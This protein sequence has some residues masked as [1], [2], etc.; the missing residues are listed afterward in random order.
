MKPVRL[1]CFVLP[2]V[3]GCSVGRVDLGDPGRDDVPHGNGGDGNGGNGGDGTTG[4]PETGDPGQSSPSN[5]PETVLEGA[6]L[7]QIGE[8]R[9]FNVA[10]GKLYYSASSDGRV[11]L[12]R[13]DIASKANVLIDKDHGGSPYAADANGLFYFGLTP[14]PVEKA[15]IGIP[16]TSTTHL[17]EWF[18]RVSTYATAVA[19]DPKMVYWAE[20]GELDTFFRIARRGTFASPPTETAAFGP[21]V[22]N[23][24]EWFNHLV[25]DQGIGYAA[26]DRGRLVKFDLEIATTLLAE[27]GPTDGFMMDAARLYWTDGAELKA[28]SRSAAPGTAPSV[29]GSLPSDATNVLGGVGAKGVYVLSQPSAGGAT[30]KVLRIDPATAASTELVSKLPGVR[31]GTFLDKS[32]YFAT[33]KGIFRLTDG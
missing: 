17:P 32:L 29:I 31:A 27:G 1:L 33:S 28:L 20:R 24:G 7:D 3:L 19:L 6:T 22:P 25:V 14:E 18:A 21:S 5:A 9:D 13:Y 15:I 16:L 12:F 4:D 2:A 10:A 8:I 30:G 23:Q 26:G 11:S